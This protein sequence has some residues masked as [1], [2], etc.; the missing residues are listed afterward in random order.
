MEYITLL[1]WGL[2]LV[3]LCILYLTYIC[4]HWAIDNRMPGDW[5]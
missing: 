2:I 1:S 4:V 5:Q 3:Q